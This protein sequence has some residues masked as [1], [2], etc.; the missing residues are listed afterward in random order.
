MCHKWPVS[1]KEGSKEKVYIDMTKDFPKSEA[2]KTSVIQETQ[3]TKNRAN[4]KAAT[5]HYE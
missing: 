1:T 3:T 4:G 2:D 5:K